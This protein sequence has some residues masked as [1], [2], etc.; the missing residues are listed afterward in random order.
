MH[1]V[2]SVNFSTSPQKPPTTY[3]RV[4]DFRPHR[5]SLFRGATYAR[6]QLIRE[7]IWYIERYAE[8]IHQKRNG[9]FNTVPSMSHT[10]NS[11]TFAY[12]YINAK[13]NPSK[14]ITAAKYVFH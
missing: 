3:T 10:I 14:Q 6:E 1:Y 11:C 5:D 2:Y 4:N 9:A 7:Y 12:T 13:K 8:V